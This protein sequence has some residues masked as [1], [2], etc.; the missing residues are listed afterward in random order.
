MLNTWLLLCALQTA[1][2]LPQGY[3]HAQWGMTAAQ[4]QRL[5]PITKADPGKGYAFAEHMEINP[6]VYVT[7]AQDGKRIEY[8]FFNGKLYKVFVVYDRAVTSPEFYE[9]LVADLRQRHGEPARS[10]VQTYFGFE[11]QHRLWE[12]AGSMLDVRMGAG[13]IYEVRVSKA[14]ALEKQQIKD[15]KNAI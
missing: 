7:P 13:Y 10:Y 14:L 8:Y 12:D 9:K 1:A 11:V 5:T 6:D 3:D 4:L 2:V 15:R